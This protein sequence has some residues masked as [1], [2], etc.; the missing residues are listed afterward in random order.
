MA[1]LVQNSKTWTWFAFTLNPHFHWNH[2]GL[3]RIAPGL[4]RIAHVLIWIAPGLISIPRFDIRNPIPSKI[5]VH[6]GLLH[7]KSRG[8]NI[9]SLM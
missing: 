4:I 5:R 8:S 1:V 2:T 6:V 7:Y 3:I 9:L